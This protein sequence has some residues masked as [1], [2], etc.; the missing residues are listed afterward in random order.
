MALTKIWQSIE[1]TDG[2]GILHSPDLQAP[3]IPELAVGESYSGVAVV[4][5]LAAAVQTLNATE[6]EVLAAPGA[7]NYYTVQM[8][9]A[10]LD[11]QGVDYDGAGAGEDLVLKYTDTSGDEITTTIDH[12]GFGNASAD[13][14]G[15]MV[16]EVATPVLNAAVVLHLLNGEWYAAAGDGIVNLRIHYTVHK[17]QV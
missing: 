2:A 17:A 6:V 12:D 1:K 8:V 7:G 3:D 13:A 14:Y 5:V 11:H 9:E 16:Q 10:F 4:Q 15:L